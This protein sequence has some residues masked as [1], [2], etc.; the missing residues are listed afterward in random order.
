MTGKTWAQKSKGIFSRRTMADKVISLSV[1]MQ[2][3]IWSFHNTCDR[4]LGILSHFIYLITTIKHFKTAWRKSLLNV[5][6]KKS[7]NTPH[8]L[9]HI[10]QDWKL[11]NFHG[12]SYFFGSWVTTEGVSVCPLHVLVD[13]KCAGNKT[14]WHKQGKASRDKTIHL[15]SCIQSCLLNS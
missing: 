8:I 15:I 2:K 10:N 11:K 12:I 1:N 14:K 13:G 3:L 4:L 9:T 7:L 5:S 6:K